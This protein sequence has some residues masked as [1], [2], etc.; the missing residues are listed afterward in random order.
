[1]KC[2]CKKNLQEIRISRIVPLWKHYYW[3]SK[4]EAVQSMY[5]AMNVF[6]H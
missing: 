1:M 6:F 5:A 3:R 2:K 4:H